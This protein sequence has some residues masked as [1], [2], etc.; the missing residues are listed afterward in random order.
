MIPFKAIVEKIVAI[1]QSFDVNSVT[2]KNIKI[3]PLIRLLL[4]Q[5]IGH[6]HADY[7]KKGKY[8]TDKKIVK[9][10][11]EHFAQLSKYKDTEVLFFSR[12]EEHFEKLDNKHYNPF[13]DPMIEFTNRNYNT[14]KIEI[15]F[16]LDKIQEKLPRFTSTVFIIPSTITEKATNRSIQNFSD[17]QRIVLDI[18]GL[19]IDEAFF[20]N[21]AR[22][23]NA[24]QF[25]FEQVLLAIK[26]K[27]VFFVY[28]HYH[29]AMALVSVCKKLSIV[30][31]DVQHGRHGSYNGAYTH[32]TQIPQNGYEL[33]PD[34][35]W[36]WGRTCQN[37]IAKCYPGDILNHRPVVGGNLWVSKWINDEEPDINEGSKNFYNLLAQKEKVILLIL[38]GPDTPLKEFVFEAMRMSPKGWLWLIRLHPRY[39]DNNRKKRIYDIFRKYCTNFEIEYATSCPLY[40]L[41]KRCDHHL[42]ANS[43]TFYE[44]LAFNV[45]TTIIDPTG[46]DIYQKE[47][48]LNL[49]TYS[50]SYELLLKLINEGYLKKIDSSEYIETSPKV[51]QKTLLEIINHYSSNKI[52]EKKMEFN[53]ENNKRNALELN[54]LGKDLYKRK[55][56]RAALN[57]F[58]K[59]LEKSQDCAIIYNNI[60]ILYCQNGEKNKS[61]IFFAKA[62]ETAPDDMQI[63]LNV[64]ALLKNLANKNKRLDLLR[65]L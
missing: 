58:F 65:L 28:F 21:E 39:S 8:E 42:T 6:P 56:I 46:L 25:F 44:A 23:I 16:Y 43:S 50:D 35:F 32:W 60:G 22:T 38:Q 64:I 3:W 52:N 61:F 40:G 36:C 2:F 33:L 49:L 1:E 12:H 30:T 29:V 18:T 14:L 27:A 59:A 51:A 5:Q 26:P 41:L 53:A 48:Q 20:I 17:L 37:S 57:I 34:Y 19:F 45:P 10:Q 24:W 62:M 9:L 54:Q 13:L 63:S 7:L 55:F 47:Y 15:P 11:K 4:R 31:A